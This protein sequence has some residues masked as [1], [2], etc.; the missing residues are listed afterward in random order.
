MTYTLI[1]A[2]YSNPDHS[3]AIA[4]TQEAGAVLCSADI[5]E[6]LWG[7]AVLVATNYTPPT[8]GE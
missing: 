1:S 7:A 5:N 2:V 4:I 3:A 8:E 6:E